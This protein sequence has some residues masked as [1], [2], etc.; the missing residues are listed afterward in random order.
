MPPALET[1]PSR[2]PRGSGCSESSS[3]VRASS[4]ASAHSMTPDW[5]NNA[6]TPTAGDAA[7]AVCEAP[8]RWPP[9]ERPPTTAS[10]GLRSAKRRANRPNFTAL[11]NDSR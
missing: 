9:V 8:A 1:M 10:S 2:R 6:L 4:S 5:A 11:P 3:A 7:D